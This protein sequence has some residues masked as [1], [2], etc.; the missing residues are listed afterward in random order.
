MDGVQKPGD[1]QYTL[2][3]TTQKSKALP[4]TGREGP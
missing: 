2:F 3:S 1:S 4:V